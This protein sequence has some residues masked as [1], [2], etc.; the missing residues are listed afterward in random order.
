[1]SDAS[2]PHHR[3][4]ETRAPIVVLTGA[5]GFVGRHLSAQFLANGWAV[6]GIVRPATNPRMLPPG[7]VAVPADH[8]DEARIGGGLRGACAVVHLAAR[9][10][11]P[12]E[13]AARWR[14][15]YRLDNVRPTET[16]VRVAVRE[17][18][19][20][21]V[22]VS[23]IRVHGAASTTV[24][25]AD[26]AP[27]PP[28]PYAESKLEAERIVRDSA[29]ALEWVVVRPTF[30]YGKGGKGN[31]ERLVRLTRLACRVP[32]PLDGLTGLRSMMYVENLASLLRTCVEH[33]AAAGRVL[34]AA[35]DPPVAT[36]RLIRLVGEALG[37]RPRLFHCAP[38][39]L[40]PLA[41]L[42][43][44]ADDLS[45]LADDFV[46]DTAPLSAVLDWRSPIAIDE[47]LRRSVAVAA[48]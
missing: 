34:L 1:V 42:V 30:V 21:F 37:C 40:R 20:R 23:T 4:Q 44:R 22:L 5:T 9:V 33:P 15:Q 36:N 28:D 29:S 27:S 13:T 45:R 10:H 7:V 31:F 17:G 46:V 18:V 48:A 35:D 47:A 12:G 14:E 2:S 6:R 11:R 8:D 32:L 39:L 26:D 38:A 19:R 25:R 41:A 43:G 24:C 3:S 16:L